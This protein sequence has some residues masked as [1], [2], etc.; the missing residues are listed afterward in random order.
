MLTM[1]KALDESII[2]YETEQAMNSTECSEI[3]FNN[4]YTVIIS[5]SSSSSSMMDNILQMTIQPSINLVKHSIYY[6]FSP[7]FEV[8]V[9]DHCIKLKFHYLKVIK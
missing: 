7:T 1:C 2:C 5:D 9:L 8:S 4:G 6:Y 3:V